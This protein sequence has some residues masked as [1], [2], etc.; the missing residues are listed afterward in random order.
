MAKFAQIL[1]VIHDLLGN[2]ALAQTGL[3]QLKVA[4]AQFA[5]GNNQYPL[6]YESESFFSLF[7]SR[8]MVNRQPS[9]L[10]V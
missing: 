1:Y 3:S 5:Q 7:F 9:L 2:K 4:F 6:F 10:C 8:L